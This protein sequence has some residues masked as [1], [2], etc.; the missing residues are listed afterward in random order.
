MSE[1]ISDRNIVSKN[2]QND[3]HDTISLPEGIS[4]VECFGFGGGDCTNVECR[5]LFEAY[6]AKKV[7]K[8]LAK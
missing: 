6:K 2:E 5:K 4:C 7:K 1:P 8:E 3:D